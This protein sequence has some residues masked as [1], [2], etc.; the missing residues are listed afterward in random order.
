M[1]S[2]S[3]SRKMPRGIAAERHA[4]PDLARALRHLIGE[5]TVNPDRGQKERDAGERRR[6]HHRRAPIHQRLVI[7]SSMVSTP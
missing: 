5:H 3:T 1:P 2:D 7:R 4:D 6:E